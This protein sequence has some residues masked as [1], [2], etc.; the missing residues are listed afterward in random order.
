MF[1]KI[2]PLF[3][4]VSIFY[5]DEGGKQSSSTLLIPGILRSVPMTGT[6][7][8]KFMAYG[9]K[10]EKRRK[11]PYVSTT[12]PIIGHPMRTTNIPPKKAALPLILWR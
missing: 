11:N 5:E 8:R 1:E 6:L 7:R 3:E 4:N 9:K 10:P 2:H 12:M